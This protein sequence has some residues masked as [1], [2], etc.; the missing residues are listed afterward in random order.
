M[1]TLESIDRPEPEHNEKI[2]AQFL[3][4][5]QGEF[6]KE[7]IQFTLEPAKHLGYTLRIQGASGLEESF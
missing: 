6:A 5:L 2:F 4:T 1:N 7:G 3:E